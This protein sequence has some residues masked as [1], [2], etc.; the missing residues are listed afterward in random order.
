MGEAVKILQV[1][2]VS[3]HTPAVEEISSFRAAQMP[4]SIRAS[5][6]EEGLGCALMAAF[7][8]RWNLSTMPL[9]CGW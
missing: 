5:I 8:W 3:Y 7:S 6:Q 2:V 4:R 9:D 1:D